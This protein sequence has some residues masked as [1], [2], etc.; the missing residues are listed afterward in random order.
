MQKIVH[1]GIDGD[2]VSAGLDP[3]G[4]WA[5][6]EQTG[7]RHRQDL[8][9]YTVDVPQRPN[10]G[11]AHGDRPIRVGWIISFG[12]TAIDPSHQVAIGQIT[13]EQEQ[14]VGGLVQA[15]VAQRVQ[16]QWTG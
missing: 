9:R 10:N 14:S 12:E 7:Q 11:L 5:G 2:H 4:L 8:V 3:E 13:N 6:E 1:Q 15:A 16:R